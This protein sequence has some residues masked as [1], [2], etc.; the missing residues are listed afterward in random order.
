MMPRT[1]DEGAPARHRN[2]L[3][4]RRLPPG[5]V[6]RHAKRNTSPRQTRPGPDAR[7]GQLAAA[8]AAEDHPA[9]HQA[10]RGGSR[11][12]RPATG[13]PG[14][15]TACAA[16]GRPPAKADP[17]VLAE[18]RRIHLHHVLDPA[19]GFYGAVFQAVA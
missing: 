2:A 6:T 8:A 12:T 3:K 17:L 13:T 7:P 10:P 9:V 11:R 18:G 16:C 1:Q 19:D 14:S 5:K 4:T 15:V